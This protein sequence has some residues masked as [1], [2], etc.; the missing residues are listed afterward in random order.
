M[1]KLANLLSGLGCL[2]SV[3][4]P[5]VALILYPRA[6]WLFALILVGVAVLVLNSLFAKDPTPIEV[7]ELAERL[8]NGD[9]VGWDVDNYEH[10]NPHEPELRELWRRTMEIGGLPE[11]WWRL[12][13]KRKGELRDVI[14]EMR[15][16]RPTR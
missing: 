8:L 12:D 13:E 14:S 3:L 5:L 16:L 15:A 6:T 1:R 10:W 7:A 9:G 2:L 4:G 11:E